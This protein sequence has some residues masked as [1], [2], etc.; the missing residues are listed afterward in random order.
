MRKTKIFLIFSLF[1]LF[2][3]LNGCTVKP[4]YSNGVFKSIDSADSWQ[5]KVNICS[6][7]NEVRALDRVDVNALVLDPQD[8]KTIYLGSKKQG[9]FVSFD[10]AESWQK[11]RTFPKGEIMSIAV[12]P[13]SKHIVCVAVDNQVFRTLDAGRTWQIIYLEAIPKVIINNVTVDP[14]NPQRIYLG[15][16]DGRLIRSEDDGFSW[17][18]INNFKDQIREVLVNAYD[19]QRIYVSTSQ[20]GI[21]RSDNRGLDWI[22]LSESLKGYSGAQKIAKIIFQSYEP[23]VLISANDYGLLRTNDSG[24]TWTEYKLLTDHGKVKIISFAVY[25]PDPNI[26]YYVALDKNVVFQSID[27]GLNWTPKSVSTKNQLSQLIIDPFNPNI[28]YL[29]M[30]SFNN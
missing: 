23:E 18:T 17:A 12:H 11:I 5:Q 24:E 29:G 8:N 4:K 1:F 2:V 6:L 30:Q 15:L 9:L 28:L 7:E 27:G 14:L 19:T 25:M 20:K 22:S 3:F 10:A 13:R 16:S 26:I 21:F